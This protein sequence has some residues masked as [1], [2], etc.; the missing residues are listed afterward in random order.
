MFPDDWSIVLV[1][2][3]SEVDVY[4]A[5]AKENYELAELAVSTKQH[6]YNGA[7]SR[8]Y[9][10]VFQAVVARLSEQGVTAE[11]AREL[12]GKPAGDK[13]DQWRHDVVTDSLILSKVGIS[14]SRERGWIIDLKVQRV[15]ADYKPKNTEPSDV[16]ENLLFAKYL[17]RGLGAIR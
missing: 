11:K 15:V 7:A 10:A 9:Y 6:R 2:P 3:A 16:M 12:C 14:S 4:L 8:M 17:L 5:K 1:L 13:E